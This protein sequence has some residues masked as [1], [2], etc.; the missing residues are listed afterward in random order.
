[1]RDPFKIS[2][3][4]ALGLS[5]GRSSAYMLWRVLESNGGWPVG[6]EFEP[7]F[8]NTGREAEATLEFVREIALRWVVPIRW[9]E[10]R[11]DEKG[12][13]E[14]NFMTAARNG[15]PYE[16]LIRKK[17]FLP[18]PVTRFCTSDLKII[19]T[20]QLLRSRG[21]E[22][23]DN[24]VGFRAD[25]PLRVAKIRLQPILKESPGVERCVQLAEAGVTKATVRDFWAKQP[26]DL[27]LP[28]DFDGTTIDGNCDGCFLKSPFQRVSAM[29]RNPGM[30]VWWARME[31]ETGGRFTKDGHSYEE[32][33]RF[34]AAQKN[35]FD[36]TQEAIDCLCG[37]TA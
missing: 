14:V 32:M 12:F 17:K 22:E 8:A 25:E 7:V 11:D 29:Q 33:G 16:A 2:G 9:V 18:N 24:M 35:F 21:W 30:S 1:M 23:W 20:E 19:P 36:P 28:I 10:Y 5:G 13:A 31:K 37:E 26:F 27:D 3:P 6:D 15:E 34:A 4:T